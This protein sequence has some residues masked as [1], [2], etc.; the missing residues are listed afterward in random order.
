MITHDVTQHL[1]LLT[2]KYV[3][4]SEVQLA[5]CCSFY[6]VLFCVVFFFLFFFLY[7]SILVDFLLSYLVLVLF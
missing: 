2:R 4:A 5:L 3:L 7:Q 1:I 6:V